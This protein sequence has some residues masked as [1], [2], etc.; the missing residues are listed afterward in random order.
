[1]HNRKYRRASRFVRRYLFRF[2]FFLGVGV[3][4]TLN[5]DNGRPLITAAAREI[6]ERADQ[7]GE[8]AGRRALARHIA[9]EIGFLVADG[10]LHGGAQFIA[11]K[12]GKI[13]ISKIFDLQLV[14]LS[15]QPLSAGGGNDRV[16]KLPDFPDGILKR[17]IAVD[18][19]FDVFAR[20]LAHSLGKRGDKLGAVAGE[21]LH[22]ILRRFVGAEQAVLFVIA[23]AVHARNK[24]IVQRKNLFR[25]GFCQAAL[26]AEA[27]VDV[28][29]ENVFYTGENGLRLIGKQDFRLAATFLNE[30]FVIGYIVDAGER[31]QRIAERLAVLLLG[32]YI[33]VGVNPGV[34]ELL[35]VKKM[36]S[37]LVR[38]IAE[39]KRDF[40]HT[41][42][43]TAQNDSK[44]VAGK[45]GENDADMVTA[46]FCLHII[47]DV[48]HCGIVAGSTRNDGL[49][50][51]HNIAVMEGDV[52]R[53]GGGKDAVAHQRDK[54]VALTDDR[55][56]DAANDSTNSSHNEITSE[57]LDFRRYYAT[58]RIFCKEKLFDFS[59]IA[60]CKCK[61]DTRM[62]I[63][64][65]AKAGY[66]YPTSKPG[67][68]CQGCRRH[69]A[70]ACP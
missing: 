39:H 19:A 65:S 60:N 10:I 15:D 2:L 49:R 66:D 59:I 45:D 54:I 16:S 33:A 70:A 25:A 40:L 35:L 52:F 57:V 32:Q 41:G 22:L 24:Q 21:E 28:A 42:R 27:S 5:E 8:L 50:N 12:T 34:L 37:D 20:R 9:R 68:H 1:M 29:A 63:N 48:L 62:N 55:G 26:C 38:G 14:R 56:T 18:H 53:L 17:A 67:W 64:C 58:I 3:K 69:G 36:V 11:G 44:A 47:G 7:I 61:L 6:A 30:F 4:V 13:V 43:N 31:V 23:A 46:E 51:G